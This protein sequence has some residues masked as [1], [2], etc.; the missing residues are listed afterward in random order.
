MASFSSTLEDH[1]N[2]GASASVSIPF[3][4]ESQP[5]TPKS[6]YLQ[7]PTLPP[8]TPPPSYFYTKTKTPL[9]KKHSNSLLFHNIFPKMRSSTSTS[10]KTSTLA[11]SPVSSSPSLSSSSSSSASSTTYYSVPSSPITPSK[12]RNRGRSMSSPKVLVD[13]RN[14]HCHDRYEDYGSRVS[15]RIGCY[16]NFIKVFLREFH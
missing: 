14:I 11:S 1:Y 9:R 4:W 15:T 7:N 12:F 8:L 6:K 3:D 5:G 2:G 16:L 10:R 13:S